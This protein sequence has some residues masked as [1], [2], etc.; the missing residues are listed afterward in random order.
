MSS[1]SVIRDL[2]IPV[3]AA[4]WVRV[5]PGRLVDGRPSLLV[6]MGQNNGGPFVLDI[7]LETGHCRQ[8][9]ANTPGAEAPTSAMRSLRTG[10]LWVGSAWHGNLHRYDPAHPER[11]LE[12]LGRIDPELA[13]F[14]TSIVETP[15]GMIWIGAYPGCSLTRY[16]PTTGEFTRFGRMDPVDKYLYLLAADDGSLCGQ[17][18]MTTYRMLSIDPATGRGTPIGP[19]LESP[20]TNPKR[21]EFFK[22][23]DGRLYLDSYE[24][25]LLLANGAATPVDQLPAQMAGVHATYKHAYQTILPLPDGAIATFADYGAFQFRELRLDYPD[26]R[27]RTLNLDWEGAGTNLWTLHLGPDGKLYGSSMLPEHLFSCHLDGGNMVNHGQCSVSGGEAYS[28]VN[29]DGKLAIGSYP[30]SRISLFDP[31]LPYRFGTG[32]GA[33]PIDVGPADTLST[34]PHSM[35]VVPDL[36]AEGSAK[37]GGK[38]WV[39]SAADYGL[40]DGSLAWFDPANATRGSTRGI[41]PARTPFVL[42]WLP[43]LKQIL[44]GF[45]SEPGTGVSAKFQQGGYALWDPAKNAAAYVGDFGD[46]ELVDVCSL[47]EARDGLVYALSGRNPRLVTHYECTPAPS[48]LC[49]LDPKTRRVVASAPLPENYGNLPFESGHILRADTD[50]TLYGATTEVVFRIKP[51]TVETEVV[52]EITGGELSVVGPILD[53][54]LYFASEWRVRAVT[55]A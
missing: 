44:V 30:A 35:I 36:P 28:M 40:L 48:R 54:T 37:A 20:P 32:P 26:G 23:E 18:K 11:G 49:L 15:D 24:G 6:S 13:T 3:K 8:F 38:I 39:G 52:A 55:W 7:D 10:I 29:Y 51:G 2:G 1:S 43:N 34:R 31:K 16:N 42:L 25:P 5:H 53:R 19:I 45:N 21:Y 9:G 50:G 4:N 14:P 12:N 27:A 41:M 22:G 17:V 47:I 46:A 33:N